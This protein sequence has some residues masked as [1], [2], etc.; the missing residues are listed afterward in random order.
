MPIHLSITLS[1]YI[2][3]VLYFELVYL[4]TSGIFLLDDGLLFHTSIESCCILQFVY[5]VLAV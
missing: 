3:S 2:F 4:D 5:N 1:V